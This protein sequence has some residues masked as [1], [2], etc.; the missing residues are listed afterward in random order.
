MSQSTLKQI[1]DLERMTS[2]DLQQ[3]W[4]QLIG[5]DP[6]R[7][8]REFLVKR[9]AHRL[10]ELAFGGLSSSA[11]DTMRRLLDEAGYDEIG[12]LNGKHKQVQARSDLPV[13]GT[14]LVREWNGGRHEVTVVAGGFEFQG[15]RYRSLTAIAHAI[16]GTHWNGPAFFGLRS[17][18]GGGNGRKAR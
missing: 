16:T 9:L 2:A 4:W 8:N 17:D 13:R 18:N 3:R 5:T 11:R 1:A 14:R 7:Y 15:R 10:Q 6:P 12:G